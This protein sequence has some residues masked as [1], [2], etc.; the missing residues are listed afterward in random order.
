MSRKTTGSFITAAAIALFVG[1]PALVQAQ[2]TDEQ[3][4][5]HQHMH[6]QMQAGE[7]TE[8]PSCCQQMAEKK[9]AMH[10]KQAEVQAELEQ[11]VAVVNSTTGDTQQAAIAELLTKLVAQKGHAGG[12][13]QMHPEM[14]K[15]MMSEGM[16]DCPMMKK[17]HAEKGAEAPA[18]E[19]EDHSQHH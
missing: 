10:A 5:G 18:P 8:S 9:T 14:M 1:A 15:G 3:P 12:M 6:G 2:S 17:K 13:M 19:T 11:L 16:S 4:Q 7:D